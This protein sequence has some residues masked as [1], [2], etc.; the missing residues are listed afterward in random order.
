MQGEPR[1]GKSIIDINRQSKELLRRIEAGGADA[2]AAYKELY[3]A[4]GKE[5]TFEDLK[6]IFFG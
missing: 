5:Y 1:V 3:D 6:E 4:L 2:V